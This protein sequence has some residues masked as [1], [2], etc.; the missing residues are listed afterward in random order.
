[1]GS[2]YTSSDAKIDKQSPLTTEKKK[3]CSSVK[4][5]T[6][7]LDTKTSPARAYTDWWLHGYYS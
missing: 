6:T 4:Q 5:D 7:S 1:M 2:M 3:P